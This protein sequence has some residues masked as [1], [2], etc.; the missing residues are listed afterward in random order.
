MQVI[1]TPRAQ[2]HYK[3]LPRNAQLKVKKKIALIEQ[4]VEIGKKLEGELTNQY[5]I[6]AWPYR[7]LYIIDKKKS[8]IYV[9]S[10]LHRQGA[11]K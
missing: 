1:I 5:V 4:N 11:Y 7:I 2:K 9:T 10:I 6:R 3:R 8:K